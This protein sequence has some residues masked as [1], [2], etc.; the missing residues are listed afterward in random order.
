MKWQVLPCKELYT[1][2]K[3]TTGF[4]L[5]LACNMIDETGF[6]LHNLS[7]LNYRFYPVTAAIF[8]RGVALV[9]PALKWW[10]AGPYIVKNQSETDLLKSQSNKASDWPSFSLPQNF[11]EETS[12]TKTWSTSILHG[13][14]YDINTTKPTFILKIYCKYFNTQYYNTLDL[15]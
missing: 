1:L 9:S 14:Y 7:T 13:G 8:L 10:S 6:T 2:N 3:H 11:G 5:Q 15:Q 4:T 12:F